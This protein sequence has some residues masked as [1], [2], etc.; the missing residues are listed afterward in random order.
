[1]SIRKKMARSKI[2]KKKVTKK[3][4][5]KKKVAKKKVARKKMTKISARGAKPKSGY[6]YFVDKKGDM[7]CAKMLG[8]GM[9]KKTSKPFAAISGYEKNE[10]GL[11][12]ERD[13]VKPSKI[14]KDT[15]EK[16]LD[17]VKKLL[18]RVP[19]SLSKEFEINEM[20]VSLSFSAKGEF[21]G[22]GVGGSSTLSFKIQPKD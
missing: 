10:S 18:N 15:L 20:T 8:A 21:L 19:K 16:A 4:A 17:S 3:I 1:M 7:S 9:P 13:P 12:L 14:K 11:Y 6:L 5:S 2:A 22:I